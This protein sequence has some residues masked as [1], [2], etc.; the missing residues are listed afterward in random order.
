MN[1]LYKTYQLNPQSPRIAV[2]ILL[3]PSQGL[4]KG[5]VETDAYAL[6]NF[7]NRSV[8]ATLGEVVGCLA[9]NGIEESVMDLHSELMGE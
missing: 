7:K 3:D 2:F 8:F 4:C 1:T 6:K 9:E 5:S